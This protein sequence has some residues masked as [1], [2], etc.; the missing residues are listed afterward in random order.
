MMSVWARS[1]E[2]AVPKPAPK[3]KRNGLTNDVRQWLFDNSLRASDIGSGDGFRFPP[4]YIAD[5]LGLKGNDR[6]NIHPILNK[7]RREEAQAN[8]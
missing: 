4:V 6:D 2:K 5:Q 7:L 1:K 3:I 8:P